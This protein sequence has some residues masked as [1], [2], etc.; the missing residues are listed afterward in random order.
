[1]ALHPARGKDM[2][3]A[4]REG[5][6]Q[7]MDP[8]I[9]AEAVVFLVSQHAPQ[10]R[11]L[12]AGGGGYSTLLIVD[13]GGLFIGPQTTA[14]TIRDRFAEI[15][16]MSAPLEFEIVTDHIGRFNQDLGISSAIWRASVFD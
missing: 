8:A 13:S 11:V 10:R 12:Y 15:E 3:G 9:V 5:F 16:A 1:M 6:L 4:F 14:E 7:A 2:E